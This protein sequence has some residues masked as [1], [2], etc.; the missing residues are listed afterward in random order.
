MEVIKIK[1]E[2]FPDEKQDA[3]LNI[4]LMKKEDE[5]ITITSNPGKAD[6]LEESS[7]HT[8]LKFDVT[9]DEQEEKYDGASEKNENISVQ[10]KMEH[11]GDLLQDDVISKFSY[12]DDEDQDNSHYNVMNVKTET[13]YQRDFESGLERTSDIKT[14]VNIYCGSQSTDY[15]I[16]QEDHFTE[17]LKSPNN[18]SGETK[19]SGN[20][21]TTFNIHQCDDTL[22]SCGKPFDNLKQQKRMHSGEKPYH[23]TVCGK[24]FGTSSTLKIHQRIHT[25]E[26]PYSCVVCEKQFGTNSHLRRHQRIHTGDKPYCCTVCG[27][28]FVTNNSLK[29]H[30]RTHTGEKPYSCTVCGKKFVT[31]GDLTKHHRIHT[32]EKPYKC[33]V[34]GKKF[35]TNG[36][37]T[38]HHRIHTGEKPYKC[39]VCGK[40]FVTNGD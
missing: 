39:A 8:I 32:G 24:Q 35:V 7:L 36:D 21:L 18:I 11:P 34:C 17:D 27:K 19:L 33:A 5:T 15:V 26:K 12:S 40:K 2:P 10:V 37:L 13:E 20:N 29:T 9:K 25:G 22:Y 28:Y 38:K 1:I 6:S 31:N 23:C 16:K 4:K 14:S 3:L 30:Q